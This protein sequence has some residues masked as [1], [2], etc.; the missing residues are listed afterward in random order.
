MQITLLDITLN[1]VMLIYRRCIMNPFRYGQVVSGR[2]FCPRPRLIEQLM[3]FIESGQNVFLQGERRTGKTSLMNEAVRRL[4]GY[5]LLY[6]DLLEVKSIGDMCRRMITSIVRMERKASFQRKLMNTLSHL[7]PSLSI[8]PVTGFPTVSLD[9]KIVM[10]KDSIEGILDLIA[11]LGRKGRLVVAFDEF[12]DVLD[13][14]ESAAALALLRSRIQFHARIT[15]LFADSVRNRMNGIFTDPES[16]FFKSAASMQVG[17][18]D[19]ET[20]V[21]FLRKKFAKGKREISEETLRAVI[22]Q[23]GNIPGD[24][25]ELCACIWD[26]TPAGES[27]TEKHMG[28]ALGM[29]FARENKAYEASLVQLTGQ[30]LRCLAALAKTGGKKPL[31]AEFLE[32]SG[33]RTSSSVQ[34]ALKRLVR[35]KIIYRH[36]G[37]YRFANHFFGSWLIWKG[38]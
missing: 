25:Q 19:D 20:F 23:T 30:Q 2:D 27:V 7:R 36:E 38:Y 5:R 15:Y 11:G 37:T 9:S 31:S 3:S 33:I 22:R 13:I 4:A 24:V 12:Q 34:A 29:I 6:I 1:N 16:P 8:D 14:S 26:V 21:P 35:L 17:P 28:P 18:I 10:R 32:E